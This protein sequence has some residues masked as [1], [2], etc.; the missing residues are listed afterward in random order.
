MNPEIKHRA[1]KQELFQQINQLIEKEG[2]ANL[3][4]RKICKN[5]DISIGT[6]YHY[7]PDKSD[8]AWILFSDIDNYFETEVVK[9]FSDKEP[10][11]LITFSMEYG[12]FIMKRGVEN[13]RCINLAP[14]K[15]KGHSYLDEGRSIFLN[16]YGIFQRGTEKEQFALTGDS[17]ET[18]R[19]YMILLRGYCTDWAKREGNYDL[20]DA[21]K[22]FS[23][24]FCKSLINNPS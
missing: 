4:I 12:A 9:E 1:R 6:F 10:D 24:L 19:M 11:N 8:I 16:L 3:T 21:L 2:F 17:L 5:L 23:I 14:L 13:C 15:S 18:A 7:F 22:R 20:V